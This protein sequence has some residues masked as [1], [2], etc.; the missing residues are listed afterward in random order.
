MKKKSSLKQVTLI[1]GD[2]IGP[3]VTDV[4]VKVFEA[5]KVPIGWDVR[6]AGFCAVGQYDSPLPLETIESIKKN[7][8]ALKGP[9]TTPIGEGFRS[10]NADL[11]SKL[12]L[13]ANVRPAKSLPGIKA[14]YS[15]ID[16]IVIRENTEGLYCG[17]EAWLNKDKTAAKSIALVTT[18]A[19]ERIIRYAFEYALA[20]KRKKITLVH[21]ANILKLT[22]GLFLG[23]G[24]KIAAEYKNRVEFED[25]II[26]NTCM[27]LVLN[28]YRFDVIVATN[29][30]GDILSDLTAGLIG[31]LGLAPAANIG[32]TCAL[33]EAVHG[34]A[35]DI[36][37][38]NKA[39][40]TA[41]LLSSVMLL[42]YLG[43]HREARRIKNAILNVLQEGKIRT[44]D[45]SGTASTTEFQKAIISHL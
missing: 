30:F 21:K 26:D 44:A 38:Q 23:I 43:L 15:D 3:E 22:G 6:Q 31:G 12:D 10:I 9:C 25:L 45:I 11:R 37:G 24:K 8:A 5:A 4:V 39:N 13:Y 1:P 35:P 32:E 29:L 17:E 14:R 27:Q 36:A 33:F 2:G 42:L 16:L 18:K 7:G 41:L 28:P 34:S 19:S 20:E 40:P